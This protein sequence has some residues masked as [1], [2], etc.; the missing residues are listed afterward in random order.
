MCS[1]VTHRTLNSWLYYLVIHHYCNAYFRMMP[2]FCIHILQGSVA[3]CLKRGG[4]LKHE[5]VA[6]FL[7]SRLV[8]KNFE[9]RVIVGEVMDKSLVGFFLIHG[10]VPHSTLFGMQKLQQIVN[11]VHKLMS[12]YCYFYCC[13]FSQ[14]CQRLMSWRSG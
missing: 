8:K 6:N 14:Q 11:S 5:F 2:F 1:K 10:V 3:T 4:I 12:D 9:N 7:L 13:L